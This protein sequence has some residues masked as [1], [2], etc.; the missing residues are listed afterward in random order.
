MRTLL[1]AGFPRF[2]SL[3]TALL[4]ALPAATAQ[5]P[6]DKPEPDPEVAEKV[7]VLKDIA[8]DKKFERDAEGLGVIDF[9]YQKHE[10][11]LAE[12]DAAMI[13]KALD[14]VLNRAKVRPP[15]QTQLYEAAAVALGKHGE[16]GAKVLQK[17]YEKKR[18]PDRPEWVPLR[19]KLLVHIG[20]T[21]DESR[22]KFLLDE[23]RRSPEPALQAAAG[24]ALGN[25]ADSEE[26]LRKEIVGDLI[27]K[28]GSLAELASQLGTNIEAQNARNRLAAVSGKWNDT[29]KKLTRQDFDQFQDWQAWHNKN[30]NKPW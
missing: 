4:L 9:L 15:N 25:F 2:A 28:Y 18:F 5:D 3:A 14:N 24:E 8:A 26:K 30:K 10:A 1:S 20:R 19:E 17:A 11:G 13:V 21:K 16:E 29:L 22:V 23:A 12:K 7:D 6:K 27:V